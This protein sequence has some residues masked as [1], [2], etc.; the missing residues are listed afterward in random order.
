MQSESLQMDQGN[1]KTNKPQQHS[2]KK[3]TEILP[4]LQPTTIIT[5]KP[6]PLH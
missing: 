6:I 1:K 3:S 4:A 2:D 5:G